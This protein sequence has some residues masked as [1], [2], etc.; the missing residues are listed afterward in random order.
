MSLA[1]DYAA[2]SDVGR[3]RRDNQDSG[4]AGPHLLM[5]ADG[6][7][8]AARGDVAS[9]T[10]VHQVSRL[11]TVP[12]N[13]VIERIRGAIDLTH[14]KLAD[15][16]ADNPEIEGTSTTATAAVF[17]GDRLHV[18]HVG[19]SRAYLLRDGEI[20]LLTKDHTFVQSLVDEGRITED[21]AR[22]HP[23]KNLIL[24]AVDGVHE[25]EPDLFSV[26]VEAGDRILICSDGC[27]GV[28]DDPTLAE[29][30][31]G[32]LD[33][34]AQGLID[35]SLAA[36]SSDNVTVI[37]AEVVDG[38]PATTTPLVVGAAAG[39]RLSTRSVPLLRRTKPTETR[40][41]EV[42]PE[43]LRYA[44]RP[45]RRF[46]WLRRIAVL[47]VLGVLVWL[48]GAAAYSWTQTQYFVGSAG[49]DVAIYQGVEADLPGL[50][51]HTLVE[52]TDLTLADLP[53]HSA[54]AVRDGM[55]A[56]SIERA[57]AI[58]QNLRDAACPTPT[59]TPTPTAKGTRQARPTA[60]ASPK[61]SRQ[62]RPT[63]T[64]SPKA[65]PTATATPKA[66]TTPTTSN[67]GGTP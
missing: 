1:L 13:D 63:G 15:L 22:V 32:P 9:A 25:P 62:A 5:V 11:D 8:G 47:V 6:V 40:T 16:V 17:D 53:P 36:G 39:E 41:A 28:L 7:G 45:P 14:S 64:A 52:R 43:A 51:M 10:A 27:C 23:H 46:L 4:Y 42:D 50:T 21:E 65:R 20:R 44:P 37:L 34:A 54:D 58:V 2:H 57:R 59:P 12:G 18:G 67:C 48:V 60:S 55:S 26:P 61:G 31:V 49:G 38:E 30:M 35:A 56:G 24:R 33:A 66:S 29:L 3:V 19:D